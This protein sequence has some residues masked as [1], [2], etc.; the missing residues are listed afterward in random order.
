MDRAPTPPPGRPGAA[1]ADAASPPPPSLGRQIALNAVLN[2][3]GR[4]VS[5]AGWMA[6]TPWMLGQLGAERFGL[7]SLL[8]VLAGAYT[9]FDLGL[10]GSLTKF[11]AEFRATGDRA[12]LRAVYTQGAVFYAGLGVLF[13]AAIA[14]A[15]EPLLGL[16]RIPPGLRP[17]AGAALLAAAGVYALLNGFTFLSSVL[18]GLHRLDLW[19]RILMVTT[20][21]QLAGVV[22]VLR[23]G[24]GVAA[25][26]LNTGV[27]LLVGIVAARLVIRRLAPEIGLDRAPGPPG[28]L[29]RMMRYSAALQIIN[30]GVL[31]QFQLDK[32][33][34][35]SMLTLAAVGSYEL[36]YRLVA[37]LWSVPALLLPPLLPAVAHLDALGERERVV[38]LYRRASRYVLAVAFPIAAG[39]I[40]L[41]PPLYQAWLG[42]GHRDAALAAVALAAMLAV[43]I[44]TG[45][46]SAIVRGAGRPG[47]E[48]RYQL[49]SMA[50]HLALSL[51]LI[52]RWGFTGGLVALS[53]STASAS[54]WFGWLFHRYLGEPVGPFLRQ[55][56]L[57]PLA[58]AILAGVVAWWVA[59]S[60]SATLDG[61]TR[62]QALARLALGCGAFLAVVTA[63]CLVTRALLPADVRELVALLR[64]R[65]AVARE[66]TA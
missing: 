50:L 53:V 39:V 46:G 51:T 1:P 17:E 14:L 16:F 32:V 27:G 3:A 29:R 41:A 8:T 36:G 34:F 65:R 63:G 45:V 20:L 48:A 33:L 21:L 23:L 24:G 37:A 35:G 31:A 61:W 43:N 57:P 44:L 49:L 54:L 15:R 2:L 4:F 5:V 38:R 26:F 40:A 42:A 18:V 60:G 58:A 25:L 66:G 56:V 52:P 55:V 7:W 28:L 64:A 10:A 11:V 19:N 6:V 9:A 30:L 13:F 22:I 59:G 12:G 62:P 47:L